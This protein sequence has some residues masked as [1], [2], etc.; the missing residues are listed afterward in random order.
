MPTPIPLESFATSNMQV[1]SHRSVDEATSKQDL[2]TSLGNTVADEITF[3]INKAR[4]SRRH[5][6]YL[7]TFTEPIA[8]LTSRL[9]VSH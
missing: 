7:Y 5:R 9:S 1:K 4:V 6:C 3:F 8:W 2:E